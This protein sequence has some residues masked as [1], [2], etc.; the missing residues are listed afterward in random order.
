MKGLGGFSEETQPMTTTIVTDDQEYR[1]DTRTPP[2]N[3]FNDLDGPVL[4]L[5]AQHCAD[6]RIDLNKVLSS[7]KHEDA[8]YLPPKGEV[9]NKHDKGKE[10]CMIAEKMMEKYL[11]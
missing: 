9:K 1:L 4:L 3:L 11:L 8:I 2:T 7:L 10:V 6:L 5:S